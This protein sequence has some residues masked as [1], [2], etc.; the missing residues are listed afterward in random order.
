MEQQNYTLNLLFEVDNVEI[1]EFMNQK[2][3]KLQQGALGIYKLNEL[4]LIV[5]KL[6]NW[7][8]S[9]SKDLPVMTQQKAK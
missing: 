8:Y 5:L 4:N 1:N 2:I 9:L 6:G 3:Q 7:Q